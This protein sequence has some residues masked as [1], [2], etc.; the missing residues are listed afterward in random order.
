MDTSQENE[1]ASSN[2]GD[3]KWKGPTTEMKSIA[4]REKKKENESITSD[5]RS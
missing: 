4:S 2:G 1:N 3:P 5:N